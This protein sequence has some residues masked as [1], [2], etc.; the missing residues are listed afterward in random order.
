M[1][2]ASAFRG[3]LAL[4]AVTTTLS[5]A[6]ADEGIPLARVARDLGYHYAFLPFEN[7]VSLTRPGSV[8]VV[9]P[10]DAFFSNN[11]RREPVYGKIPFYRDNDVVVSADFEREIRP[12][13][14]HA[15]VAQQPAAR[16][17]PYIAR[18]AETERRDDGTVESVRAFFLPSASAIEIVGKATPGSH[19][20]LVLRANLAEDMPVITVDGGDAIADSNGVFRSQLDN[21]PVR[22]GPSRFFVEAVAPGDSTP[23]IAQVTNLGGDRSAHTKADE[24]LKN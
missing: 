24:A 5:P 13:D 19:V 6:R 16:V 18:R 3:T 9:R 17:R 21:A 2:A 22:F 8:I 11:D 12:S 10:G 15:A 14:R 4:L 7:V 23:T 1:S 20:S